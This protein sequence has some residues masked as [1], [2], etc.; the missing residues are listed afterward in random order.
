MYLQETL[1]WSMTANTAVAEPMAEANASSS[2]KAF[3]REKLPM[4][5]LKNTYTTAPL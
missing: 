1:T 4:I 3:P 2:G 5:T